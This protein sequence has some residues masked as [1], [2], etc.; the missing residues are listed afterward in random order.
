MAHIALTTLS[1]LVTSYGQWYYGQQSWGTYL[2]LLV[3]DYTDIFLVL[4]W[5]CQ[6]GSYYDC[7]MLLSN[8]HQGTLEKKKDLLLP[9]LGGYI[10]HPAL[11]S[12]VMGRVSRP[13]T[14]LLLWLKVRC[15]RFMGSL[16]I[17]KFQTKERLLG[18]E[19]RSRVIQVVSYLSQTGLS[20]R[21]TSWW[22]SLF[23]I[24]P[25]SWQS[26]YSKCLWNGCLG[27][28]MLN[29]RHLHYNKKS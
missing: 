26:V 12:K 11:H 2:D 21:E 6:L 19:R 27:D 22:G 13:G 3:A 25:F 24:L 9:C 1:L 4:C 14:L 17:D 7:K 10:T 20:K 18:V 8:N 15:L 29:V 23:F 16:F 28:Q 5:T